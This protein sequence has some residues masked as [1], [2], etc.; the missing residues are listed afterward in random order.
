MHCVAYVYVHM[1]SCIHQLHRLHCERSTEHINETIILRHMVY[2]S[3]R[4]KKM[5]F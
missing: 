2:L 3:Y 1:Y 5:T 4:F